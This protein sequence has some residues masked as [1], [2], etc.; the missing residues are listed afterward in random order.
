MDELPKWMYAIPG[1]LAA[2]V[3]ALGAHLKI[4][5]LLFIGMPLA[6]V[7]GVGIAFGLNKMLNK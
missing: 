2:G 1:L 3:G 7:I 6:F 5:V 4:K